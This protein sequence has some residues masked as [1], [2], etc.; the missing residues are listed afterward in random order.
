MAREGRESA[1]EHTEENHTRCH[2]TNIWFASVV[3]VEAILRTVDLPGFYD[4]HVSTF[5]IPVQSSLLQNT[6][7]IPV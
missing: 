7:R 2:T 1:A 5:R 3:L 4:F 6:K